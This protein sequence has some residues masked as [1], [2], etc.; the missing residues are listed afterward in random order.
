MAVF[1]LKGE[2]G[3]GC[4]GGNYCPANPVNRGQMTAFL[5]KTFSLT[6]YGP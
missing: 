5:V 6:L 1:L 4:R 2:H 3:G